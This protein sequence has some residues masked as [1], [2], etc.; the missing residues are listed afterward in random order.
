MKASPIRLS[1][2]LLATAL[3]AVGTTSCRTVRGAGRDVQHVG[4][5]IENAA[6]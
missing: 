2:L 5:H 3:L 1:L 6:R 4:H